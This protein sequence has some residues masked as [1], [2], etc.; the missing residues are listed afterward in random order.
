MTAKGSVDKM[1]IELAELRAAI[2]Q[3]KYTTGESSLI[4][5]NDPESEM[6][7]SPHRLGLNDVSKTIELGPTQFPGIE[8]YRAYQDAAKACDHEYARELLRDGARALRDQAGR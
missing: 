7:L 8:W 1:H 5:Q 6:L 2:E 4:F 3:A